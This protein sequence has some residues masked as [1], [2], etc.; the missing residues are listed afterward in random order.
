ME[1]PPRLLILARMV[2]VMARGSLSKPLRWYSTID[3]KCC[4]SAC[5]A[6]QEGQQREASGS[7]QHNMKRKGRGNSS[8][9]ST[10]VHGCVIDGY[11]DRDKVVQDAITQGCSCW[12]IKWLVHLGWRG[13]LLVLLVLCQWRGIDVIVV[14]LCLLVVDFFFCWLSPL[15]LCCVAASLPACC[16]CIVAAASTGSCLACCMQ[17]WVGT[18]CSRHC[19][20]TDL[21]T[22]PTLNVNVAY[23]TCSENRLYHLHIVLLS[24]WQKGP[25][26]VLL[27]V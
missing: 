21:A 3:F 1:R 19:V 24:C 15:F 25:R 12:H 27:R 7:T 18:W 23:Y 5:H 20:V 2:C 11:L 14:A 22:S 26:S 17:H 4:C 8:S 10:Q 9:R 6:W 16:C 13:V